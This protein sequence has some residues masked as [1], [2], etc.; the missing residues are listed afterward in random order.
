[1]IPANDRRAPPAPVAALLRGIDVACGI[2][3]AVAAVS[4][5]LLALILITE[6]V[7]TSFFAWSQPWA[8]EYAIYLQCFVLFCGAGWTLR[9]GGH[10]R[11]GILLQALPGPAVRMLDMLGSVFAIGVTGFASWTLWQQS[12]R[13][14]EFGS[15]SYYPMATPIWIPQ[16]L[17]TL[18]VTLLLLA[19]VARLIRLVFGQAPDLAPGYGGHVE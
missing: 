12:I 13:T 15:T 3:A 18:G 4:A 1:V 11:V 5:A 14:F 8:I 7:A 9:Q 19:F 10:I 2:G 6:V 17:L 16:T